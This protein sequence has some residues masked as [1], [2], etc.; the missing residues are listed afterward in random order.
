MSTAVKTLLAMS[1]VA[2]AAVSSAAPATQWN[3]RGI[4]DGGGLYAPSF[5]P[6]NAAEIYLPCDMS[7]MFHTTNS[8]AAWDVV[9]FRQLQTF[10][11]LGVQFAANPQ[12]RW[13]LDRRLNPPADTATQLPV[14][15]TNGGATW[16]PLDTNVWPTARL[17]Q[18]IFASA[19]DT[20]T[21]VV[22][23]FNN[24]YCST[25]GGATM[26]QVFTAS[27]N[28][29]AGAFFDPPNIFVGCRAGLLVSTNNGAAFALASVGGFDTN[30]EAMYSFCGGKQ[31]GTNRFYCVTDAKAAVYPG[32]TV[33]VYNFRGLYRLDWGQTNWVADTNGLA[34]GE[35]P[36]F[37]AMA[38][39]DI[40]TAYV[41]TAHTNLLY[42]DR[43]TVYRRTGT[44]PW[45]RTFFITPNNT[46]IFSGWAGVPF[47]T[48]LSY[49]F[50]LGFAVA[51]FDANRVCLVDSATSQL[52]TNSGATWSQ[53]YVNPA[54][55]NVTNGPI[56]SGKAYRG[57]GLEPTVA[58]WMFWS[59]PTNLI[60]GHSDIR[61][62]R[63]SD[64]GNS[65]AFDYSGMPNDE[66][67]QVISH[68]ATN[69]LYCVNPHLWTPFFDFHGDDASI[70][71]QT[72]ALLFSTNSGK[73]WSLL[74]SFGGPSPVWAA[75][76]P[77]RTN[78]MYVSV[79]NS[80]N[81]GICCTT[82]LLAGTS[83]SW[84]KLAS[85][86][87][88]AGHP[89]NLSVLNDGTLLCSHAMHI[90]SAASVSFQTNSGIYYCTNPLAGASAVWLDRST[91]AMWYW[92]FDVTI[93]PG[94]TNQNTWFAGV[95]NGYGSYNTNA[96]AN[97]NSCGGLYATTNR[98]ASWSRI[99]S[100][101][102][103][104]SCAI[105]PANTNEMYLCTRASGLWYC[106]DLHR[107]GG[108]TFQAV[109]NYP[110]R[111]P[112]RT[113]FNPYDANE[114]W[115]GSYGNGWRVG[116]VTPL[117][118]WRS[119]K[120]GLSE[121]NAAIADDAADADGD[122]V[123]NILEYASGTDPLDAN[124]HPTTPL[125]IISSGGTNYFAVTFQ[126]DTRATDLLWTV[127]TSGDLAI[128]Q[129]GST[130]S[131]SGDAP[132][133]PLTSEVSRSG[134]PVETIVVRE[135]VPMNVAAERY[136]RVKVST[137]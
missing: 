66:V 116:R 103:V 108:P 10:S 132:N 25:N 59:S 137:P 96:T 121:T 15:S 79:A 11:H 70:D 91:N 74:H 58:L 115:I 110:F 55:Q 27:S 80:T 89:Y 128:W 12:I 118:T 100:T 92:T 117:A 6:S 29:L 41:A 87:R 76:D 54:D 130:Y 111:N 90:P 99:F 34:A 63:S 52:T 131:A 98:G 71:S 56:T 7:P 77:N 72:G 32:M 105:N 129:S 93:D 83:A 1:L 84:F 8:G 45:S 127:E 124:S 125:Q 73:N 68:P 47:S 49:D 46:N 86:P 134:G 119:V 97:P 122:G 20:Q 109:T 69:I 23:T 40:N 64:G 14:V 65:W 104:H 60:A 26:T 35:Y 2:L 85:H 123:A 133:T 24:L 30:A 33:D 61:A 31:N 67:Y 42:P 107:L 136:L 112:L 13:A 17:A 78:V 4:G 106:N 18:S 19:L 114:I 28:R 21:V 44:A 81:G 16:L 22:A 94:D 102:S 37:V 135:N 50:P 3:S 39:N 120:F 38:Q 95:Y 36:A 51:P 101:D 75:I 62:A 82:N 57:V 48:S 126:R 43:E 5:N 88:M 9:D 53:I 113:F